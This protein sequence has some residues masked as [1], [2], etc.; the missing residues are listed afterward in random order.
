MKSHHKPRAVAKPQ[1]L[2]ANL[3]NLKL[4][5]TS[6]R[7]PKGSHALRFAAYRYG[8]PSVTVGDAFTRFLSLGWKTIPRRLFRKVLA[9][10]PLNEPQRLC[11][12]SILNLFYIVRLGIDNT[13][14]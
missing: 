2:G 12:K 14:A 13:G 7:T 11:I 9:L 4:C 5:L 1:S 3:V 10:I 6:R 8:V